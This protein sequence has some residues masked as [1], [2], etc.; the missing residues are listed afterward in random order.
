MSWFSRWIKRAI[1]FA[2]AAV[3]W[4]SQARRF[5]RIDMELLEL[6][7]GIGNLTREVV[8]NGRGI[9]RIG[10]RSEGPPDPSTHQPES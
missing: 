9:A 2:V 3:L 6:D 4:H 1:L 8:A 10:N 5:D 7:Q